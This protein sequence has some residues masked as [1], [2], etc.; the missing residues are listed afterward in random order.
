MAG[1]IIE[2]ERLKD[3]LNS[4]IGEGRRIVGP[5]EEEGFLLFREI[6]SID[7]AKISP[8]T[9]TKF[10]LK[11][12]L[13]P[14]TEKV[15]RYRM[16]GIDV[17]LEDVRPEAMDLIVFGARPCDAASLRILDSVFSWDYVDPFYISRR[18]RIVVIG[19]SCTEP[20]PEC[21]CTSVGLSPLSGEGSDILLTQVGDGSFLIEVFTE[22]GQEIVKRVEGELVDADISREEIERD[23]EARMKRNAKLIGQEDALAR[24][25]DMMEIWNEYGMRC[26][27]CGICAFVCPTCHCF[28]ISEE[29][30]IREGERRKNWDSCSF[31]MFT[32]HASGHNPRPTQ[33]E[34]Y[35]QRVMHKFRYFQERF[36][37]T[38]CVGC[39]RCGLYCPVG[40]DI[41]DAAIKAMGV[42]G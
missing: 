1:K 11:E 28:D 41:Y 17:E 20:G 35:R 19:I 31:E 21:F 7:E 38:M 30:D 27:Q 4:L 5:I 12:F 15:L 32:L 24:S 33:A 2:Y 36:G 16:H 22:R 29:A 26:L 18:E 8:G 9:K 25:F 23:V 37:M 34:R 39:G 10:P 13:F 3:L 6:K 40:I 14:K 42:G